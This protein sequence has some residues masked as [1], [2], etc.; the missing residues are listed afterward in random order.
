[1][2]NTHTAIS[3]IP[4]PAVRALPIEENRRAFKQGVQADWHS[5]V[6]SPRPAAHHSVAGHLGG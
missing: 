3:E 1:L 5:G 4:I 2:V 6:G